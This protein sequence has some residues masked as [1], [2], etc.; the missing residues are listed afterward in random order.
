[1]KVNIQSR[2]GIVE[3][4]GV[5]SQDGR[6]VAGCVLR[7]L[8][9]TF[10]KSATNESISTR[11]L[12]AG[13]LELFAKINDNLVPLYENPTPV[14]IRE[15]K[16]DNGTKIYI[17]SINDYHVKLNRR[18]DKSIPLAIPTSLRKAINDAINVASD[19]LLNNIKSGIIETVQEKTNDDLLPAQ[20][21]FQEIGKLT[22]PKEQPTAE[23]VLN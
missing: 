10:K 8:K 1:M 21:N 13:E 19:R 23:D 9:D 7:Q 2:N 4:E 11:N 3:V 17:S 22:I 20:Q 5:V 12:G 14:W 16:S 18:A 6:Y 15:S